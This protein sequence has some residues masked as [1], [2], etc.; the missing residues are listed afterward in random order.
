MRLLKKCL[1]GIQLSQLVCELVYESCVT[2][3][4]L[5]DA[6]LRRTTKDDVYENHFI[7]EGSIVIPNIYG[8]L[9]DAN[10]YEDPM[11]F[12]PERFMPPEKGDG[13][14]DPRPPCFGFGRRACPGQSPE[15]LL[16]GY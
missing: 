8:F 3:L 5:V 15:R 2:P 14:R 12:K 16:F 1:D 10:E 9:H 11:A 13:A 4:I 7:P 6:G